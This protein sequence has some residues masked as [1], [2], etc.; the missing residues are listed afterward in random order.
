MGLV[1]GM[2]KRDRC[3]AWGISAYRY[4]P[5]PLIRGV[6][7]GCLAVWQS[8]SGWLSGRHVRLQVPV[9]TCKERERVNTLL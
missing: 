7:S 9:S 6:V 5:A 1:L 2:V 3:H 8:L 4:H